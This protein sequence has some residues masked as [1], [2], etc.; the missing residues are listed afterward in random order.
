MLNY[1]ERHPRFAAPLLWLLL[2]ALPLLGGCSSGG[3]GQAAEATTLPAATAAVATPTT[4]GSVQTPAPTSQPGATQP[5]AE[6]SPTPRPTPE[7]EP[8]ADPFSL[9]NFVNFN[10]SAVTLVKQDRVDL[11]GVAPDESLLTVTGPGPSITSEVESLIAVLAYDPTYREWNQIWVSTP[12]SGTASPLPSASSVTPL[13]SNG[14]DMVR[15]GSPILLLRTTKTD[16]QAQLGMWRWNAE[17][18][19]GEPLRMLPAG[20]GAEGNALFS[21]DLDLNVIDLD[22][23]GAF[24]VI[25]DNLAGVQ[26][27]RWDGS[28]Y[29]PG[30]VR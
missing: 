26:L 21:A 9:L 24:E 30:E 1:K 29:V 4:G 19:Q 27:W 17:K 15:G 11:D 7:G 8:P 6:G 10:T 13:G 16:N 14:K 18:R 12:I 28:R 25:A 22:D 2:M 23:D 3:A 5:A 20:G